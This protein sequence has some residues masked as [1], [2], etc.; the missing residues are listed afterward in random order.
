MQFFFTNRSRTVTCY[1]AFETR[2]GQPTSVL[3]VSTLGNPDG[4]AE[5]GEGGRSVSMSL[6]DGLG[7]GFE[8]EAAPTTVNTVDTPK[9]TVSLSLTLAQPHSTSSASVH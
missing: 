5:R 4:T 7:I 9:E 2:P 6:Y 8:E 1:K 3:C